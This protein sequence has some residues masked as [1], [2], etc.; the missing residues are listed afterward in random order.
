MRP[1]HGAAR[2][3]D[4]AADGRELRLPGRAGVSSTGSSSRVSSIRSTSCRRA[5]R[6]AR[7]RAVPATPSPM[8]SAGKMHYGPGTIAMA[9]AGP[10]TGG[11][12]FFLITGP[13]GANLDGNPNYTIFGQVT[14][15]LD[16]AKQINGLMQTTDG[17]TTARRPRPSTSR[18]S[19]SRRRRRRR[20]PHPARAADPLRAARRGGRRSRP[21]RP[22]HRTPVAPRARSRAGRSADAGSGARHASS[23][24]T[25]AASGSSE[26]ATPSPIMTS[27]TYGSWY[28]TSAP[29]AA[30]R[31]STVERRRPAEVVDPRL[32]RDADAEDARTVHRLAGVVERLAPT[33]VT[34]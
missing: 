10:N 19:R 20:R 6:S 18:R 9:N 30:S 8:S 3:A 34:T 16:V 27:G 31:S 2:R 15:G 4:R 21:S 12:Q 24:A 22:A 17:P 13:D 1:D 28:E 32:E 33:R 14:A 7:A 29:C 5:T 11:S 26:A 25:V 23:P